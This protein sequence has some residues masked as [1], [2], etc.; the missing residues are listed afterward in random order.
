MNNPK[1]CKYAAD[2]PKDKHWAVIRFGTVYIPGDERSRTNPGH[3]YQAEHMPISEY[4]SFDDFE[5][6][7]EYVKL[8]S[9]DNLRVLDVE[10]LQV[11]KEV[12]IRMV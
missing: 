5:K 9:E 11:V 2:I 12:N 1:Y 8:H 10:P 3:G 7:R 6:L 4:H